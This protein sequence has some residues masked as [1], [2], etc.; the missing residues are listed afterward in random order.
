MRLDEAL[1]EKLAEWQPG[2]GRHTLTLPDPGVG[3]AVEVTA[4][5]ADQLGCLVWELTLRR[6]QAPV[7]TDADGL[8]A[9]AERVAKRATGLLESLKVIEVDE[10]RAV[11]M[12][13]SD[14]PSRKGDDVCY[15]ELLLRAHQASVRRY[16]AV[17]QASS[18]RKQEAFA[19]THEAIAKLAFD[20]TTEV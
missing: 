12:L 1:R 20:L 3:W 10:P 13:R 6:V 11:A 2:D 19:L 14:E 17:N 8:R 16:R 9:W 5:R 4:D 18:R 15:Y 7:V